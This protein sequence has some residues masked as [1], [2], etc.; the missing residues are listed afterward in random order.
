[1]ELETNSSS[2]ATPTSAPTTPAK[3]GVDMNARALNLLL[4]QI[5][6]LSLR[7][8]ATS[9]LKVVE[10]GDDSLLTTKNLNDV[11]IMYLASGG[12]ANGAISYLVS[13]FRRL[14]QKESTV[15][16]KL[17]EEYQRLVTSSIFIYCIYSCRKLLVSFVATALTEPDIFGPSGLSDLMK[18]LGYG[19]GGGSTDPVL[20]F[21]M[22]DLVDEL[23]GLD[24]FETV[25]SAFPLDNIM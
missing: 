9:P 1:M 6:L 17:R 10:S 5:F 25:C 23:I 16:D 11:V 8:D 13:C 21:L 22:K 7:K 2:N 4:E 15:S 18:Q 19:L 12:E 24:S 3:K 14:I 20:V